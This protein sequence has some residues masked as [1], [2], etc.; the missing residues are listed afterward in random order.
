MCSTCNQPPTNGFLERV[1]RR[2]TRHFARRVSSV[3]YN[4]YHPP[5][6]NHTTSTAAP[7]PAEV[8]SQ[9]AF[10]TMDRFNSTATFCLSSSK[11]F[12][13]SRRCFTPYWSVML[14]VSAGSCGALP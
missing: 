4:P 11:T 12:E 13:G 3:Q 14:I 9:S 8:A 2:I 6:T 10:R 1:E 5:P 7:A